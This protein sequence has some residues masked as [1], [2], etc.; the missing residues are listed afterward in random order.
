MFGRLFG[1]AKK[2][3]PAQ[4]PP[5]VSPAL[6]DIILQFAGSSG[7]PPMPG[8]A[9]KAFQLS[10]DPNADA[11]DFIEVIQSDEALAARVIKIANSVFFDRGKPSKT[12]EE[13]VTVIG[14]NELRCLLNATT[15]AEI[16]PSPHPLRSQFWAHDIATGLIARLLGQRLCADKADVLFLG[17]LMHDIGK[18]FMLQ[19]GASE[20]A[21]LAARAIS[22]GGD[23]C[24]Q[25]ESELRF[26]HTEA[27]QVLAA[28][29]HFTPDLI[30]MIRR[31]HRSWTEL[32]PSPA[33]VSLPGIIRAA[34]TFAHALG[35]G[36]GRDLARMKTIRE[37]E[38]SEAAEAIGLGSTELKDMLHRC[39]QVFD[40]E[41]DLYAS[42]Q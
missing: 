11:H 3:G 21:S 10:V 27:G 24:S 7:I 4:G 5:E 15:L 16:F 19:R 9:Q 12:I 31:H 28:R 38:L 8:A 39:R 40:Q 2:G 22:A 42:P 26:N 36:H 29:W 23:F 18:L 6:T 13:S 35:L 37:R 34:D 14:M 17:G 20:Y 41:F 1:K 32:A 30:D 33:S 25:E